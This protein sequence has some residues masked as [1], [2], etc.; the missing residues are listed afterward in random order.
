MLMMSHASEQLLESH[1][2]YATKSPNRPT[3]FIFTEVK[4]PKTIR[5]PKYNT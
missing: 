2:Q 1:A 4:H 5:N 3:H